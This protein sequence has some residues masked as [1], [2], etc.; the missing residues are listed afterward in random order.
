MLVRRVITNEW[1][2]SEIHSKRCKLQ[3]NSI[4]RSLLHAQFI[5]L[6]IRPTY[7]LTDSQ[8]VNAF[9]C[10]IGFICK[11]S[12]FLV[13]CV[14]SILE[15]KQASNV[16]FDDNWL[17]VLNKCHCCYQVLNQLRNKWQ[18]SC[19]NIAGKKRNTKAKREANSIY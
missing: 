19:Y 5:T 14:P 6:D 17:C 10:Y 16:C 8:N 3:C 1:Y 4:L 9:I 12:I 18:L 15:S 7:V 2:F 13:M 11:Q